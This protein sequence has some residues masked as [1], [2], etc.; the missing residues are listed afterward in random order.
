[1]ARAEVTE[2]L[3]RLAF[4]MHRAPLVKVALT[5]DL[6][7]YTPPIGNTIEIS[8][9]LVREVEQVLD[10]APPRPN[11]RHAPTYLESDTMMML[12]CTIL[13]ETLHFLRRRE[14]SSARLAAHDPH[15]RRYEEQVADRF[16]RDAYG[17]MPNVHSLGLKKYFPRTAAL[18]RH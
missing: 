3:A 18:G 12:E 6:Y 2:P 15:V 14:H 10:Y 1:M 8:E 5:G 9:T 4:K 11:Q 17:L 13:H 16:E 7:G